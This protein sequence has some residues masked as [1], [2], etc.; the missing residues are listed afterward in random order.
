ME[1]VEVKRDA[2][3]GSSWRVGLLLVDGGSGH[4]ADVTP[5][6]EVSRDELS[7][8]DAGPDRTAAGGGRRT[9]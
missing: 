5:L 7:G 4:A 2:A 8:G 6:S 1:K 9:A 3:E